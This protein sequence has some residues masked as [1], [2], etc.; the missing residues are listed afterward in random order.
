[1]PR[2]TYEMPNQRVRD[3]E[4][5][6]GSGIFELRPTIFLSRFYVRRSLCNEYRATEYQI[7]FHI[8]LP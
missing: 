8:F 1:M 5:E 2:G 3:G 7:R 6:N 4:S